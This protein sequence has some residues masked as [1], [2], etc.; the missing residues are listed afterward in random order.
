[1]FWVGCLLIASNSCLFS[2]L[3]VAG[4]ASHLHHVAADCGDL[5]RR[6]SCVNISCVL[7]SAPDCAADPCVCARLALSQA[8]ER[9]NARS[10]TGSRGS[11]GGPRRPPYEE[12]P[13]HAVKQTSNQGGLAPRQLLRKD[14]I[15][16]RSLLT[17]SLPQQHFQ[18]TYRISCIF[19]QHH[20]TILSSHTSLQPH[21]TTYMLLIFRNET[22]KKHLLSYHSLCNISQYV[23][24]SCLNM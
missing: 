6:T 12:P 8:E 10:G 24:F 4:G 2:Q 5:V 16:E 14:G 3:G 22:A 13:V 11:A 1:M 9:V 15:A 20:H 23:H 18:P 17:P 19:A 21:S 7:F